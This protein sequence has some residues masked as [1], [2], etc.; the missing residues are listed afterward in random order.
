VPAIPR[1]R[2]WSRRSAA[3]AGRHRPGRG[4]GPDTGRTGAA[5]PGRTCA[6]QP[7]RRRL[8]APL[9]RPPPG[10]AL[11]AP[12][13]HGRAATA[14]NTLRS[15]TLI[16]Q[17]GRVVRAIFLGDLLANSRPPRLGR[18]PG[19]ASRWLRQPRPG[20]PSPGV[21][22][23]EE[24]RSWGRFARLAQMHARSL[25]STHAEAILA[26]ARCAPGKRMPPDH[27]YSRWLRGCHRGVPARHLDGRSPGCVCQGHSGP[28]R[29]LLRHALPVRDARRMAE[30]GQA[31]FCER[32]SMDETGTGQ[33]A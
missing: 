13:R 8:T 11:R 28:W 4:S 25:P 12:A 30:R 16:C 29:P 10:S 5:G 20:V 18:P 2:A 21:G 27:D 24:V 19:I 6:C 31:A 7:S 22:A 17:T 14:R 3:R 26:V 32:R 15:A 9:A 33:P 1:P 23:Y